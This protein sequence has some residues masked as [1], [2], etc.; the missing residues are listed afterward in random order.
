MDPNALP[1]HLAEVGPGVVEYEDASVAGATL[2]YYRV[3]A[4]GGGQ[5]AVS[6]EVSITTDP[7][8]IVGLGDPD[9]LIVARKGTA[10]QNVTTAQQNM[11]FQ[12]VVINN[13]FTFTP[14]G[15]SFTVPAGIDLVTVTAL[16]NTTTT[17]FQPPTVFWIYRNSDVILDKETN[18]DF[19]FPMN[20]RATFPVTPGDTITIRHQHFASGNMALDANC[21]V[22][23]AGWNL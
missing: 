12:D 9:A 3:A 4:F 10:T 21:R 22:S 2:Y 19:W 7:D 20:L 15:S 17:L 14:G 13:G 16:A 6:D 1:A 11:T 18:R 23:I 5:V 8:L